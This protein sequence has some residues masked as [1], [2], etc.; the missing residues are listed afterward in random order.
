MAE[1]LPPSAKRAGEYQAK[2]YTEVKVL[3]PDGSVL[4]VMPVQLMNA[5]V[6]EQYD[7]IDLSYTGSNITGVV[8]SLDGVVKTALSLSYDLSDN[9]ITI[10]RT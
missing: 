5:L 2:N 1:V 10:I 7:R 3:L 9:L 4:D 8:Y 6:P